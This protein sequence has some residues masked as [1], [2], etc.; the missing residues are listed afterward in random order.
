M[1]HVRLG[2][3]PASKKWRE[4]VGYMAAGDISVAD[5]ANAIADASDKSLQKATKDP[6]FLDA[7]WLLHKIPLAAKEQNF[8][9]A[10]A[11][12]GI[13]VPDN[14]SRAELIA[15][16]DAAVQ[17]SQQINAPH[18][19]DLGEMAKQAGITALNNLIQEKSP[20]LWEATRQD[21]QQSI[22][23]I[24]S[25]DNFGELAQS[26]FSGLV[27]HNIQYYLDREISKHVGP[28][29]MVPSL[30]DISVMEGALKKHCDETTMIMRTFSKDW[31]GKNAF[32]LG[33]D[34]DRK[35]T[36]G[37]AHV[38]FTKIRKELQVR[39]SSGENI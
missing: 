23:T 22:A 12:I 14:P 35:A 6:A 34:I 10:L 4:I 1:G 28:G 21:V 7:L 24:A 33:K 39:S 8:A 31:Y 20:K 30:G 32:H 27:Q 2:K 36:Q 15:G 25:T 18:V 38:A 3:L 26:F 29:R 17:K 16:Y 9:E 5:I 13:Q 37:F 19:T 11:K